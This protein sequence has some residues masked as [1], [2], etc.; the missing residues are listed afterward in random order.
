MA[1]GQDNR[2]PEERERA[3][4]M[5][6][7]IV[8]LRR[9]RVPYD[10][11]GRRMGKKYPRVHGPDVGS[12]EPYPKQYMFIRYRDA[13]AAIPARKVDAHRTELNELLDKL[14]DRAN[15]IAEKDHLA[16]SNGR[17]VELHGEPVLDDGPKLAAIA[18]M[19][20]LIAEIRTLNGLTVPVKQELG[21]NTELAIKINGVDLKDLT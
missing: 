13:L 1:Q 6:A 11:I 10:E 21:V 7:D 4:A 19:R 17:V 2:T 20:K 14:L 9:K 12:T 8:E 5:D 15:R 18:E 16:H 3:A